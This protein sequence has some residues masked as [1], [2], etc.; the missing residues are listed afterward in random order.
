MVGSQHV[1]A[2]HKV[3]VVAREAVIWM[4]A[5]C[6]TSLTPHQLLFTKQMRAVCT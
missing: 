3:V 1:V 4:A 2:T 6:C 5:G